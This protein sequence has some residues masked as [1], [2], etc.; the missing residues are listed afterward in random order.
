M[1]TCPRRSWSTG[2][3]EGNDSYGN[4]VLISPWTSLSYVG[5]S[6]WNAVTSR[7]RDHLMVTRDTTRKGGK[8]LY[9]WLR[10]Y[11]I[12]NYVCVPVDYFPRK[13]EYDEAEKFL[14]RTTQHWDHSLNTAA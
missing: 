4:Y 14:I 9:A 5:K 10:H 8:K 3:S 11:M 7:A 12:Y 13:I 6:S 1:P 2:T